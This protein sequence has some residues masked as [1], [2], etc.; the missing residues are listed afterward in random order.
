[1]F[2]RTQSFVLATDK[3]PRLPQGRNARFDVPLIP[4]TIAA[5][6]YFSVGGSCGTNQILVEKLK[7]RKLLRKRCPGVQQRHCACSIGLG[8]QMSS[9][10]ILKRVHDLR[11]AAISCNYHLERSYLR[12]D[13]SIHS[14]TFARPCEVITT[15][16]SHVWSSL[17]MQLLRIVFVVCKS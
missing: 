13:P 7:N 5:T 9:K 11:T 6:V 15:G 3:R 8:P 16:C 1:M 4:T 10:S 2:E 12:R 14:V 17:L